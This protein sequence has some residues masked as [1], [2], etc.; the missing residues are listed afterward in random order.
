MKDK[1]KK[2]FRLGDIIQ[3]LNEEKASSDE[4]LNDEGAIP[5]QPALPPGRSPFQRT[6]AADRDEASGYVMEQPRFGREKTGGVPVRPASFETA[7]SAASAPPPPDG[8]VPKAQKKADQPSLVVS[9]PVKKIPEPGE[10][11][12]EGA[13]EPQFDITYYIGIILRRRNLIIASTLILG[14][15]FLMNYLKA[16]KFYEAQAR[17]LFSP[18]YQDIMA[19]NAAAWFAFGREDQ[20][21]NT[22]LELLKSQEVLKRASENLGNRVPASAMERMIKVARDDANGLK[23]DIVNITVKHTDPELARDVANQV[24]KVYIDYIKEVKVQDLTGL[25]VKL[26]DQIPKTQTELD[27][28]ENALRV[29]KEKNRTV[30]LSTQANITINKLSTMEASKQATELDMLERKERLVGLRKEINQQDA[31]VIQSMTYS[32]PYQAR[33]ADLEFQLNSQSAEYSPEHYKIKMIKNEIEKVKEAMK[34]YIVKEAASQTFVK[35]PLRESMISSVVNMSIEKSALEARLAVQKQLIDQFDADL[36]KLPSLELHFAQLTRET[37]SLVQIL[38]M[39]KGR[40]EEAKIKRESQES[41]LKILE[42]AE[43][44]KTGISSMRFSKVLTGLLIGLILGIVLAFLLEFL[45]Q[46][47]K[48]PQSVERALELSLLGIV[49]MIEME[50][51]IID[52]SG[53]KWRTILEPFRALRANLKH[54]AT[55]YNYRTFMVCSAVKGEGKTTLAAN[56]AITFSLDGKKVILVDGDLRRAQMHHLF[57]VPKQKGLSDYLLGTLDVDDI[58]KPTVHENLSVI[59][60]GEHPHNP[61][62]LLGSVRFDQI[63]RELRDKAD[64]VIVDSPALLP[65]S[66]GLTMAPKIDACIMVLRALWT[67]L[68]A[69]QQAKN[70]LSRIGCT[71]VGGILNGI[72]HSRGYYPYYYGYYRYYAYK[73]TYEDD[74]EHGRSKM[75]MRQ[76]GLNVESA[77]KSAVRTVIFSVPQY[78]AMSR[79]FTRHLFRQKMFWVL[80]SLLICLPLIAAGL[81][82]IGLRPAPSPKIMLLGEEHGRADVAKPEGMSLEAIQ[83]GGE[84]GRPE[85]TKRQIQNPALSEPPANAAARDAMAA[86]QKQV[87]ASMLKDSVNLW[88]QAM[89]AKNISR[90]LSFYDS[91]YFKYPGGGFQ[92]WALEKASLGSD[93]LAQ[94]TLGIDS[95]SV[96]SLSMPYFQTYSHGVKT[97]DK[98]TVQIRF[99]MIWQFSNNQW[100]IVREKNREGP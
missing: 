15:F 50:K 2:K 62:E 46:S 87:V 67:P 92:Q 53:A 57:N 43:L 26:E 10:K 70:Q 66:D 22:H 86:V 9:E 34:T 23:T 73:Y 14:L 44:P 97:S 19:D 35:N 27:E 31:N 98:D 32:N 3:K 55:T 56:L 63:I 83:A 52:S 68:K 16:V 49:P 93:T 61:A 74:Q 60:A 24:C 42:W 29:Y 33:L 71:I 11:A 96:D 30:E 21:F 25:I 65:V 81:S 38:K 77:F 8:A 45:D 13:E 82:F 41:D 76:I 69:A 7:G 48:D 99:S 85:A 18:G 54:L 95:I 79:N 72:S 91:T 28:K 51:A 100:R 59:T 4:P 64:F 6:P 12:A 58:L 78:R 89:N 80:L 75:N 40:F 47:V 20:K 5:Q 39:M 37:E 94:T 88:L 17:M 84:G 90:L 1:N 36:L